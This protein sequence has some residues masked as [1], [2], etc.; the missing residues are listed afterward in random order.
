M[1]CSDAFDCHTCGEDFRWCACT[2][3]ED[4][5]EEQAR[6]SLVAALRSYGLTVYEAKPYSKF[7]SVD[8]EKLLQL[9]KNGKLPPEPKALAFGEHPGD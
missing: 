2:A 5:R 4:A 8:G 7:V 6:T 3:A 1:G 9:L